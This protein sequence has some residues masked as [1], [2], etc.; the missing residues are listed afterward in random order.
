MDQKAPPPEPTQLKTL[1]GIDRPAA[2]DI[3]NATARYDLRHAV[4]EAHA[5]WALGRA[6]E[7]T[8][9][10]LRTYVRAQLAFEALKAE[11]EALTAEVAQAGAQLGARIVPE[12]MADHQLPSFPLA[13]NLV[14][15]VEEKTHATVKKEHRDAV[16][17][18]MEQNGHG[19]LIK[20]AVTVP[21]TVKKEDRVKALVTELEAAI[22]E[23]DPDLE[24][25]QERDIHHST[26]A[27]WVRERLREGEAYPEDLVG[28]HVARVARVKET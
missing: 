10:R 21:I 28:V 13:G 24:V 22:K 11:L 3:Y 2:V 4:R 6:E 14:V 20:R 19:A 23:V 7:D 8:L 26:F 15:V 18:W 1:A 25:G 17:D 27:A 12:M 16:Y 5:L 9:A